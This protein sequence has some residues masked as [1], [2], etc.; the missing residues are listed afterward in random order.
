MY[1]LDKLEQYERREN[2]RIHGVPETSSCGD[3]EQDVIFKTVEALEIS[4][5]YYDIQ[6]ALCLGKLKNKPRPIIVRFL[7]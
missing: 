6:K 4:L 2:L 3:D 1:K 7:F 5:D